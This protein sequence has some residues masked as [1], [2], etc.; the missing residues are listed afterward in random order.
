[1]EGYK[2]MNRLKTYILKLS[3]ASWAAGVVLICMVGLSGQVWAGE[4]TVAAASD[5]NFAIKEL[6]VEYEKATGNHVKLSLGSSGNFYSQIQNG[7]PFDLYFSADIGYPKKLEEA[8]LI[9]PG[10]LYRYAVGRI[11]LWTNHTSHRD[12]SKGLEVLRDPAIKKIAIANPKHAP[13][14][15]A[16]VAAMEHFKVYEQAKNRLVLGENISQAA[17]FI[18]SGACDIGVIALSLA[19]APTMKAAGT[20]WQI[21]AD[22]HPPLEQGAAILKSSKQLETARQF[23]EFIQGTQGQEIMTRYGF[24][25]PQ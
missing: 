7:A 3:C 22:A 25:L 10:S 23:V 20:Y 4:I 6:I 8:G 16:A 13:Y 1:M 14:G 21:P 17:Q 5:L 9:V 2:F 12:V 19:L 11:V 18:E 24:T 15:R